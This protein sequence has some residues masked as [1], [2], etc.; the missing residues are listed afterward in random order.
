MDRAALIAAMQATASAKPKPVTVPVW[1]TVYVRSLTVAEVEE[2]ADDTA[3]KDD[4]N[5]IAR[6]AARLI[7]DEKG[8]RLF[9]PA[10]KDDIALLASQPWDLLRVVVSASQADIEGEAGKAKGASS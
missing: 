2:Q 9:D 10:N 5:R 1:G 3:N 6:G 4:K 8:K 7:C